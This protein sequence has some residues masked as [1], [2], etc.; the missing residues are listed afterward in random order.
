MN[1]F[2]LV[3]LGI[4]LFAVVYALIKIQSKL[5]EVT[6]AIDMGF[7]SIEDGITKTLLG[8]DGALYKAAAAVDD[9]YTKV[10]LA[11]N[12]NVLGKNGLLAKGNEIM[13][14]AS[15][16]CTQVSVEIKNGKKTVV[17]DFDAIAVDIETV[18][19]DVGVPMVNVGGFFTVIGNG[20]NISI[21]TEHP[22]QPIAQPFLDI[23]VTCTDIGDKA[24]LA[25]SNIIK[26]ANRAKFSARAIDDMADDI[27]AFA[28][29]IDDARKQLN[30]V[31]NDGVT[32]TMKD[33]REVKDGVKSIFTAIGDGA[34]ASIVQLK[35]ANDHLDKQIN[36]MF[37]RKYINGLAVAAAGLIAAGLALGI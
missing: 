34:N 10:E 17:A 11:V 33:L 31:V 30:K 29:K 12:T 4:V 1:G 21:G 28:P 2:P 23:G 13:L 5:K 35:N 22:F 19:H 9:G 37:Q 7:K 3:L 15:G 18:L 26:A 6:G 20:I 24:L 14:N 32:D 36:D 8:K 27:S 25:E 16:F